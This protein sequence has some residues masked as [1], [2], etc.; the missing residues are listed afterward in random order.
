MTEETKLREKAIEEVREY[1]AT[2]DC[3]NDY[4][5][6][7]SVHFAMRALS[8]EARVGRM[9]GLLRKQREQHR[10]RSGDDDELLCEAIGG[11]DTRCDWCRSVDAELDPTRGEG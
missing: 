1:D 2:H 6:T 7:R 9:E 5:R 11:L 3:A 10:A 8:A 4:G